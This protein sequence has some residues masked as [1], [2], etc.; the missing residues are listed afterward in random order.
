MELLPPL[1]RY[2]KRETKARKAPSHNLAFSRL[3]FSSIS[4]EK[5][6]HNLAFFIR[7]A[8][9]QRSSS[10][11]SSPRSNKIGVEEQLQTLKATISSPSMTV[12]TMHHGFIKLGT[13]Y[14]SIDELTCL[15][16]NQ[17]QQR[18]AVE[19][20]LE[21]SLALLDVCNTVQESFAELKATIMEAQ[22]VLKRGDVSAVQAKVQFYARLAKKAQKQIKKISSKAASDMEG[23]RVVKLLSEAREITLSMLEST[24][25]L[26]LKQIAMPSSSK[27]SIVSKAFQKKRV[28]CE[29]E[30]LQVLELDIVELESGVETLF[31]RMIQS[32]V[33][34][35][36][37]LSL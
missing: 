28:V 34:L 33:S 27:W 2:I 25:V 15:P 10:V 4:R 20:E 1:F 16:R 3:L 31:R 14:N 12:E 18:K 36:N 24:L 32:R 22:V 5:E 37:T 13:I 26:L 35:L 8:C 23:Y 11:P 6:L 19:E 9:H 7:M 29:E 21:R 17:R 30:Q